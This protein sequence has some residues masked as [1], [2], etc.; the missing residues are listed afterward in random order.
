MFKLQCPSVCLLV[1]ATFLELFFTVSMILCVLKKSGYPNLLCIVEDLVGVGSVAVDV[2]AS[3][4]FFF[5]T[6][7][8]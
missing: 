2:S 7:L 5:I 1:C 4:I 8:Y 3:D 6:V